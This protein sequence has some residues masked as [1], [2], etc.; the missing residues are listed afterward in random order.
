MLSSRPLLSDG[1]FY[2]DKREY[3]SAVPTI[4]AD[5]AGS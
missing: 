3:N 4:I 1:S 2:L 5:A